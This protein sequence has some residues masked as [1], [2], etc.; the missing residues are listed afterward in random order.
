VSA[1]DT[2]LVVVDPHSTDRDVLIAWASDVAE[3][4][5]EG[6]GVAKRN[7]HFVGV[8]APL[9]DCLEIGLASLGRGAT[10]TVECAQRSSPP[11]LLQPY[12]AEPSRDVAL[13]GEGDKAA[14]DA[15][16]ECLDELAATGAVEW[17]RESE[18]RSRLPDLDLKQGLG[19]IIRLQHWR[20]IVAL[21]G[22]ES[23][24][25]AFLDHETRRLKQDSL[26]VQPVLNDDARSLLEELV[27]SARSERDP[28][29]E[30]RRE[31]AERALRLAGMLHRLGGSDG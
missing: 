26:I 6:E 3:Y 4:A 27:P 16:Y 13:L 2:V 11:I 5:T 18:T 24:T 8:L 14:L 17:R 20:Y 23:D 19:H 7:T 31:A 9:A 15:A 21:A 29:Q 30:V 25:H 10:R 1:S 28:L 22:P 12:Q